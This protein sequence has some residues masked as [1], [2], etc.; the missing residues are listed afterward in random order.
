MSQQDTELDA[1][2][3]SQ[4]LK[5]GGPAHFVSGVNVTAYLGLSTVLFLQFTS[6]CEIV[7]KI[8]LTFR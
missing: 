4:I 5:I 6:A 7:S 1:M 3:S 8:S 2:V